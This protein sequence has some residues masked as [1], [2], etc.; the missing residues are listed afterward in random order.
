MNGVQRDGGVRS[1]SR[2]PELNVSRRH[3]REHESAAS[4]PELIDVPTTVTVTP[5]S[6]AP[7]DAARRAF[8]LAPWTVPVTVAMLDEDEDEFDGDV[9][10]PECPPHAEA[11]NTALTTMT[12]RS[13]RI[14]PLSQ[15]SWNGSATPMP[16]L[17]ISL[18][19]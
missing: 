17:Q 13:L 12:L 8:P 16:W 19:S 1:A 18:S 3:V 7:V 6:A 4:T 2:D 9:G 14:E 5:V 10:E 15:P 11:A